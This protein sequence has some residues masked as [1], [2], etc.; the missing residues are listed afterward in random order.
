MA[1]ILDLDDDG[2]RRRREFCARRMLS[3]RMRFQFPPSCSFSAFMFISRLHIDFPPSFSAPAGQRN[4]LAGNGAAAA[5]E[6]LLG[7]ESS[8]Y[9][10]LH[11]R[12]P[13]FFQLGAHFRTLLLRY[14]SLSLLL[15]LLFFFGVC[16]VDARRRLPPQAAPLPIIAG[17]PTIATQFAFQA[18]MVI[19]DRS[20]TGFFCGA[21]ILS[22]SYALTAA[23]CF[24]QSAYEDVRGHAY[25]NDPNTTVTIIYGS[26]QMPSLE[27]G[28]RVNA[29]ELWVYEKFNN[30]VMSNDFAIV[31]FGSPIQMSDKVQ[32]IRLSPNHWGPR[33]LPEDADLTISGWGNTSVGAVTPPPFLL[34]LTSN[35]LPDFCKE[36]FPEVFRSELMICSGC[37]LNGTGVCHGDSGGPATVASASGGG[38]IQV[39]ILSWAAYPCATSPA[40]LAPVAI[41]LPWIE[42]IVGIPLRS[43]VQAAPTFDCDTCPGSPRGA[44]TATDGAGTA[45][46]P[47]SARVPAPPCAPA[48]RQTTALPSSAHSCA[49]H[50]L[51]QASVESLLPHG[52]KFRLSQCREGTQTLRAYYQF[53]AGLATLLTDSQS[54]SQ[55][56]VLKKT[57]QVFERLSNGMVVFLRTSSGIGTGKIRIAYRTSN[58]TVLL[59]TPL[60][61]PELI[62][63]DN[64][65]ASTTEF[66]QRAQGWEV[67]LRGS[68]GNATYAALY[69]LTNTEADAALPHYYQISLPVGKTAIGANEIGTNWTSNSADDDGIP[70]LTL[71]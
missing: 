55:S 71:E 52:F 63:A 49:T 20:D 26:T 60:T 43:T 39:G 36:R 31:K 19:E 47:D 66:S 17:E 48:P 25:V 41:V 51:L 14:N 28:Y 10:R 62:P 61:K 35:H 50:N 42:S 70:T 3:R 6:K 4:L 58:R 29:S 23:H 2:R 9:R 32:S 7:G 64:T 33:E 38:P 24:R 65:K 67:A 69:L 11:V 56:E 68:S 18:A 45:T 34:S 22:P 21:S 1:P 16:A 27:Y 44:A 37:T 8:E 15:F 57:Q 53:E 59:N 46:P 5:A 40:V 54:Q 13:P 30:P 12:F